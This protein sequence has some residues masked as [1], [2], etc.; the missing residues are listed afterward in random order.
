MVEYGNLATIGA[1]YQ[2]RDR[3]NQD[4]KRHLQCGKDGKVFGHLFLPDLLRSPR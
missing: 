2:T 1:N 4:R 3:A